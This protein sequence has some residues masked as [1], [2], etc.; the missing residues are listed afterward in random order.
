MLDNGG[1]IFPL[2][3]LS[4]QIFLLMKYEYSVYSSIFLRDTKVKNFL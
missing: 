4:Y 3:F 2:L 1:M